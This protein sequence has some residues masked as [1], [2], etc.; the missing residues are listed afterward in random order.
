M[1][2]IPEIPHGTQSNAEK[3][4]FDKLRRSFEQSRDMS[5]VGYHSLN[6]TR[7]AYK[8]FGEIDFL[9]CGRPGLFVLEVKGGGVSCCNGIW[10]YTNR[11][12]R[13]RNSAEG[14][15]KQAE[16]ALHGL[17]TKLKADIPD[18]V[19]SQ[20]VTGYGVIFPDCTFSF[21]G[22]EW[23]R[24]TFIDSRNFSNFEKW[25]K[26]FF[27]YWKNRDHVRRCPDDTSLKQLQGFLRPEFEAVV[28]LYVQ[29][30]EVQ[31]RVVA[32]TED[33]MT[34]V[35]VVGANQRVMC[36][37]GAGTGKTFLA[38]ELARRWTSLG[39]NVVLACRSL[40][41]KRY[42]ESRFD[43][44][45][46]S[47]T[48]VGSMNTELSRRGL[49]S[50]DA[51]IVDEGQDLFDMNSLDMLDQALSGG[52]DQGRW[53]FFYDINNQRGLFGPVEQEAVDYLLNLH[54]AMVPLRTNCRNTRPILE[55]VQ[56]SLKADMGIKGAGEGPEVRTYYARSRDESALILNKE[57]TRLI[58]DGGISASS[59]TILSPFSFLES[60][61]SLLPHSLKKHILILDEYS[62]RMFPPA[63]ASFASISSFKGLENEAVI[64]ID[65][66]DPEKQS[67][68]AMH[69]V[70]MSRS[71]AILSMIFYRDIQPGL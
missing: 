46:L 32:L 52:L 22:V 68:F 25:L 48:L 3:R 37:G 12:G 38:M 2:M 45:G 17:I 60:S 26:N 24:Q 35:D 15:F 71:R 50:F 11:Y 4:V 56:K 64:V 33:Q 42:L 34:M 57:I 55:K 66:P 8:R 9:I 28:P 43:I 62:M 18:R 44:P 36:S 65:L 10:Q 20:F 7:H 67:S 61:A 23:D 63:A 27:A 47:T 51:M 53:C 5:I 59:L 30:R 14:P 54:P 19:I 58:D 29:T 1:R 31:E 49:S 39:M 13:T 69:Y 40:W 16:S 41:L 21:P 70:A 6:L